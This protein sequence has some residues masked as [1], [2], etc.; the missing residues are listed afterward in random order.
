MK[1][2][3]VISAFP[4]CGKTYCYKNYQDKL[5]I[6]DSDSSNFSW[7]KDG[8]GNNTKERNPEFPTN[9]IQHIKENIGKVD[10]IFVSS[11]KEVRQSLIKNDIDTILI[12]PHKSLKDEWIRRF[13]ERGNDANFITFISNNWDIFIDEMDDEDS[14]FIR[15]KLNDNCKYITLDLLYILSKESVDNISIA[16]ICLKQGFIPECE[17]CDTKCNSE[18]PE[19]ASI[20]TRIKEKEE[21]INSMDESM[22]SKYVGDRVKFND[23]SDFKNSE[24]VITRRSEDGYCFVVKLDMG[25]SVMTMAYAIDKIS[26]SEEI[27]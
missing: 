17:R 27:A 21:T 16:D 2:T 13:R 20:K 26:N 5:S 6:L 9:Y 7:I 18:C 3:L 19:Y 4:G 15:L 10:I 11:H 22:T 8:D 14:D 1:K 25:L 24:G 23:K 12:Y